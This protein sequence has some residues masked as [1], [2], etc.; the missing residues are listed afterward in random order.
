M[1]RSRRMSR[2][3]I[4]DVRPR[5]CFPPV[6]CWIGTRPS[7]AAKSRPRLNTSTRST[8]LVGYV[9]RARCTVR[10]SCAGSGCRTRCTRRCAIWCGRGR[11]RGTICAARANNCSRSC[12]ATAGSTR[13]AV[14]GRWLTGAGL[15]ASPSRIRLSRSSSRRWWTP[16]GMPPSGCAGWTGSWPRSCRPG[17]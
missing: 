12:C 9:R 8:S 1:M 11:R 10:A 6:E 15:P 3:P 4:F 2:C 7:Q 14:I 16:S 17:P 13:A 5:R